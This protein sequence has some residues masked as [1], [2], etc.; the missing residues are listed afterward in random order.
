MCP[1]SECS[2]VS[3]VFYKTALGEKDICKSLF[4]VL[5]GFTLKP[6]SSLSNSFPFIFSMLGWSK[7]YISILFMISLQNP[8]QY[9]MLVFTSD[10]YVTS[11]GALTLQ[12]HTTAWTAA[13]FLTSP[14]TPKE[15][16]VMYPL[17]P[18]TSSLQNISSLGVR[19]AH[20]LHCSPSEMTRRWEIGCN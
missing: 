19:T 11:W 14:F 8:T 12:M 7:H 10:T 5:Q 13:H 20:L 18:L 3:Y 9:L 2:P 6:S 17:C 4:N 15:T 16:K 1:L